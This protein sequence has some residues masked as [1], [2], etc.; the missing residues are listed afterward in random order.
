MR[1]TAITLLSLSL[2]PGALLSDEKKALPLPAEVDFMTQ[3]KPLIEGTCLHCHGT[4]EQKGEYRMDTK[5]AA[6]RGGEDYE[7]EVIKPAN[8][9]DSPVYWMTTEPLDGDL[10][11]PKK[12][13]TVEQQ[14]ILKVWIDKGAKWPDDVTLEE[15][16]RVNFKSAVLPIL[17]KGGPFTAKQRETMQLWL[18]QGA[19]WPKGYQLGATSEG[20]ADDLNLVEKIREAIVA[21]TSVRSES[22]MKPYKNTIPKTGVDF[23]M[24][25]IK[26]GE[27]LMGSPEDEKGRSDDEGPQHRVKVDPFWMGKFEVTWNMYEPFMI[28]GVARNKDGSPER[29][30]E[31]AEPVD[32]VS[33]PTTPYQE[34]SFG[35]GSN[36]FPA[37]CMTQH[38]ALKFCEWLSAQTG[39]YYRLPTEAEWEYA[40]RVGTTGPYSCP[41]DKL[42]EYAVMDP[43][44]VRVGYEKVGTKKPNPWGLYDMHGNVMEWVLD[45]YAAD[46]YEK[47]AANAL[48]AN[49]LVIPTQL[50]PR[51]AR[52]GS[53]YDPPEEL[54]SARRIFS[55][56]SW[57]T[58]DPQLP[59]SIWYHTDAQWLGF[60]I[61]RPLKVPE[62]KRMNLIWNLGRGE[63]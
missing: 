14:N 57:K 42:D 4:R 49:P 10:M 62:A 17:K 44:Q 54:R 34:M 36:G 23:E 31:G 37:I 6:F 48:T 29:I 59:K 32:I 58:Q 47:Q 7:N 26:G 63:E 45:Q 39:Q 3:V 5:D 13:L 30:P 56:P 43:D 9:N 60:R 46:T 11:P 1:N 33:S 25:P 28:T 40:C 50:Y 20:P 18:D 21:N 27:F 61:V 55:D 12:P 16:P 8:S 24:V 2:L 38:A 52:G 51:V 19:A 22:D 35:M 53:W 41:A 15:K